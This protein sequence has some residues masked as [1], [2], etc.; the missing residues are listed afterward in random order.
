MGARPPVGHNSNNDFLGYIANFAI[1]LDAI[2]EAPFRPLIPFGWHHPSTKAYW[3]SSTIGIA[4]A[5]SGGRVSWQCSAGAWYPLWLDGGY[6]T[7]SE[8]PW[9]VPGFRCGDGILAPFEE[10]EDG[11]TEAGDGCS[12]TCHPE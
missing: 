6:R 8:A 2:Y 12:P 9:C 1:R 11:N 3:H 5:P 4:H 10:C 7:V